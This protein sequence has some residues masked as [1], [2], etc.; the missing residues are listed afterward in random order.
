M[1][2]WVKG[3]TFLEFNYRDT[4]LIISFIVVIIIIIPTINVGFSG[5]NDRV[6][7]IPYSYLTVEG[8]IMQNLKTKG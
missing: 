5:N 2:N 1:Q 6:P 8:T 4:L 3:H 7:T